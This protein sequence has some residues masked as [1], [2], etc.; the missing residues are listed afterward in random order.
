MWSGRILEKDGTG[1][2]CGSLKKT[3]ASFGKSYG[4]SVAITEIE[5]EFKESFVSGFTPGLIK[6]GLNLEM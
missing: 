1:D 6:I 2:S 5:R 4:V 3:I